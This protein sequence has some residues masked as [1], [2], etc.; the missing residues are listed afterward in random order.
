MTTEE[1]LEKLNKIQEFKCETQTL[2]IKAAR[3]GCPKR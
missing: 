3:Q 2:E 1:L